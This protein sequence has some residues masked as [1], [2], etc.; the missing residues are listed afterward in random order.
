MYILFTEFFSKRCN[1]S[2]TFLFKSILPSLFEREHCTF[3]YVFIPMWVKG[4]VRCASVC[5]CAVSPP[6]AAQTRARSDKQQD[7]LTEPLIPAAA[8]NAN[9]K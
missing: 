6:K 3:L 1:P 8:N 9:R 4:I 2:P 7:K 5:E